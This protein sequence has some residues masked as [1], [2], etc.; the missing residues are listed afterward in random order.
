L[1]PLHPDK[2]KTRVDLPAVNSVA[3][4]GA[5]STGDDAAIAGSIIVDVL[6]LQTKAYIADGAQVNQTGASGGSAQTIAIAADDHTKLVNV[7]GS[8]AFTEGSAGVG[9]SII[10]EVIDKDVCA[11]IGSNAPVR[12]CGNGTSNADSR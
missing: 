9:V 11:Y 8:L 12:G 10:V 7:A 5:G 4:S 2:S 1:S 3:I 6:E